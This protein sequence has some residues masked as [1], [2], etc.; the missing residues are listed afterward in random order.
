MMRPSLEHC[1]QM[2]SPQCR[3]DVDLLVSRLQ[4]YA[5]DETHLLWDR[6]RELGLCSMEKRGLQGEPFISKRAIRRRKQTL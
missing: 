6:L 1:I 2:W 3:R 4:N 5:R